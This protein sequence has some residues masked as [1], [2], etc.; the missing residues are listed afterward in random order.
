[1]RIAVQKGQIKSA[2]TSAV[3]LGINT[4]ILGVHNFL[5]RFFNFYIQKYREEFISYINMPF[6]QSINTRMRQLN[7]VS[8][9]EEV[10]E[11]DEG[12]I[13][14]LKQVID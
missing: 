9:V 1:L 12:I 13:Y 6:G 7:G 11:D 3:K 4:S 10:E 5:V 8:V 2:E 14:G